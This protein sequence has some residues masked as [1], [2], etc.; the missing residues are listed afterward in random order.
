M[1]QCRY[2]HQEMTRADGCIDDPIVIGGRSYE[3]IRYCSEPGW[4]RVNTRCHD[5]N[6]LPGQ[7]HH[8]GCDVERCPACRKQ[9]ISC[10]CLWAGEEHL[11]DEWVEQMEARLNCRPVRL[12]CRR[13]RSGHCGRRVGPAR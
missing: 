6:V 3:P 4:K 11:A 10:G 2:C 5:C 7:V 8:H 12:R 1:A 9:S 13:R